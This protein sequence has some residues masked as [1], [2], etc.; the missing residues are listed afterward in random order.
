[1]DQNR[2][3]LASKYFVV[4]FELYAYNHQLSAKPRVSDQ[5]LND[6][7]D[8]AYGYVTVDLGSI[9]TNAN[10]Q[11]IIAHLNTKYRQIVAGKNLT[12]A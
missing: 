5:S 9:G 1:M 12:K 8:I 7:T 6:D 11:T 4:S 10:L 3:T 2:E